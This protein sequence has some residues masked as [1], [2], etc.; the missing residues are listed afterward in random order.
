MNF[1]KNC[2]LLALSLCSVVCSAQKFAYGVKVGGSI[3]YTDFADKSDRDVL[4]SRIKGG[5]NFGGLISF[6]LKKNN[7][8]I[9]EGGF[10]KGGRSW[11]H[12]PT[13]YSWT[14]IYSFVD[15]S[16][17]LRRNFQLK[18]FKDVPSN[19]FINVGPNINYWISGK[20][21]VLAFQAPGVPGR[22]QNFTIH[23]DD[24]VGTVGTYSKLAVSQ[25]NRWLFGINFGIGFSVSTTKFQKI[26]TELR[27]TWG[28]TYLGQKNSESLNI[29]GT[30]E[31][32]SLKCNLKTVNFSIAYVFE[33]DRQRSKMGRSTKKL[34]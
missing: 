23:L 11:T 9:A 13:G 6:P 22:M 17:A 3:T 16:M 24:T 18:L 25:A 15:M 7:S 2:V 19:W 30:Q 12:E 32:L 1:A 8:F 4:K 14:N 21:R 28:Q 26:V 34:K 33:K 29:V 10:S 5:Y 31:Q 20:G 27:L